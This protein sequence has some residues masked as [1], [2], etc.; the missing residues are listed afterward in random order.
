M[1]LDIGGNPLPPPEAERE[2]RREFPE[3]GYEWMPRIKRWRV[4][5]EVPWEEVEK[6]AAR[7]LIGEIEIQQHLEHRRKLGFFGAGDYLVVH[8][9]TVRAPD[10]GY[11]EPGPYVVEALKKADTQRHPKGIR[12]L[13][14]ET[15]EA[16]LRH[17]E[18]LDAW[19]KD[20]IDEA[21]K[22]HDAAL[23][24]LPAEAFPVNPLAEGKENE[25]RSEPAVV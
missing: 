1:L 23:R 3:C 10:G 11:L 25:Q 14:K 4:I 9:F 12:G 16:Q 2:L 13:L 8:A 17:E 18:K 15:I 19:Y 5:R 6:L 7:G 22:H 21:V 24:G 20:Q